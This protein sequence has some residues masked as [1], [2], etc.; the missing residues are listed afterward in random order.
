MRADDSIGPH[1]FDIIDLINPARRH[2]Q[3]VV[4]GVE[5]ACRDLH[6]CA[7]RQARPAPLVTRMEPAFPDEKARRD[8]LLLLAVV[9]AIVEERRVRLNLRPEE[10]PDLILRGSVP[11]DRTAGG[12][13]CGASGGK[14][15]AQCRL[16]IEIAK[17]LAKA[18][19]RRN[20]RVRRTIL[21]AAR[22][23]SD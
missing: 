16:N 7:E 8:E 15:N 14:R 9:R 10:L 2:D 22:G 1:L 13:H 3:L 12:V 18:D 4:V 5:F 17:S 20:A 19:T 23:E 11:R 6:A 21:V